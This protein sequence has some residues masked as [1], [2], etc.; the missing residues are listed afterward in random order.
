MNDKLHSTPGLALLRFVA[1]ALL[2]A[3]GAGAA[4]PSRLVFEVTFP[5]E[6]SASPLDGHI[7]LILAKD[8]PREPRFTVVEGIE[9]QQAFGLDVD[10]MQ[11]GR[12]VR[13]D[14]TTLGYPLESLKDLPPGEYRVQAVLNIYETFHLGSGKV[15]KLPPDR[16][17]GQHWQTKP[18]NLVTGVQRLRGRYQV[19]EARQPP[20]RPAQQVLGPPH[21]DRRGGPAA[22]GLGG[23][24]GRALPGGHLP[25]P[26]PPA[27]LPGVQDLPSGP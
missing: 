8:G 6:L 18:G 2:F 12:P 24:P 25:G 14:Q 20:Q 13:I 15:V 19:G 22:R 16:G 23:A 10:G 1:L 11:P 21:R 7:L 9:S 26:L 27:F 17:E 5:K 4:E 3:L